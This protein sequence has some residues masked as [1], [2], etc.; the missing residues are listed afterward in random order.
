MQNWSEGGEG[1]M[2]I[3]PDG[4]RYWFDWMAQYLEP[5]IL[6]TTGIW[7]GDGEGFIESRKP[8][9]SH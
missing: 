5:L 3:T 7:K 9:A 4:T 2:A 8:G 1:F 6:T